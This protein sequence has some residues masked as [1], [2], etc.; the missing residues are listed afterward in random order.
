LDA[1]PG[2]PGGDSTN[3]LANS[4]IPKRKLAEVTNPPRSP[5]GFQ[6]SHPSHA[7][8]DGAR[9]Q[10]V[11]LRRACFDE[12]IS[13]GAFAVPVRT[14]C[15]PGTFSQFSKRGIMRER[16]SIKKYYRDR[17]FGFIRRQGCPDLFVHF[18]EALADQDEIPE[19]ALE[20][21]SSR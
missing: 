7:L 15:A 20:T 4:Q 12:A 5:D 1:E 10:L 8:M 14:G 11:A 19:G 18:R 13:P 3:A 16:G 6:S 17:G 2:A 9:T 21:R